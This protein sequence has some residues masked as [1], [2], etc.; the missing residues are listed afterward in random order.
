MP[1][2]VDCVQKVAKLPNVVT[3]DVKLYSESSGALV[4]PKSGLSLAMTWNESASKG[5]RNRYPNDD[6]ENT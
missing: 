3:S 4:N 5:I 6:E 2:N 1:C